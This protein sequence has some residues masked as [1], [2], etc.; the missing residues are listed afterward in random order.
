MKN[1][2][3]NLG[4]KSI[5][6]FISN[7]LK[8]FIIFSST[9]IIANL[10][11]TTDYG[12]YVYVV[13]FLSFFL[14][15]PRF[16]LNNGLISFISRNTISHIRKKELFTFSIFFS[17]LL[18]SISIILMF[19]FKDFLYYTLMNSKAPYHMFLL[20]I[21]SIPTLIF[22]ELLS[23]NHKARGNTK[24]HTIIDNIFQPFLYC[25]TVLFLIFLTDVNNGLV[26]VF[27]FYISTIFTILS[28]LIITIKDDQFSNF[29]F[30]SKYN[31]E[32][33]L[34]SF[35]LMLTSIIGI[36][37]QNV[38][39]YMIGYYISTSQIAIYRIALAFG[40]FSSVT[41]LSV[42]TI[43]SPIISRLYHDGNT[44]KIEII[45]KQTTKGI[46]ILNL[47]VFSIIFVLSKKIM[48]ISGEEY[49]VGATAL[50]LVSLGQIFNSIVGAAGQ[51]NIMTE[52]R[53]SNFYSVLF[54]F[55]TNITLNFVLIGR[56]GI[57]GV[58]FAT[59]FSLMMKN[60]LNFIFLYKKL[61]IQPYNK[62]FILIFLT[63]LISIVLGIVLRNQITNNILAMIIV[64]IFMALVYFTSILFFVLSK[65][66]KHYIYSFISKNIKTRSYF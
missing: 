60:V 17:L 23:S 44:S 14:I 46:T 63:S 59:G 30:F 55:F 24:V 41:L 5:F 57:N 15:I 42:T 8:Q 21:P 32:L 12:N 9:I 20:M 1:K 53:I 45:Y 34:C 19:I 2:N 43:F 38:D 22:I 13:S 16:G 52:N 48:G 26:L 37:L 35:P 10:L 66:E 4:K 27:S 31:R 11:G 39:K 64:S 28:Y 49:V 18:S 3:N 47:F 36:V 6:F 33:L 29:N 65:E 54:A 61:R 58:A 51:I 50:I 25:V 56:Y 40:T 62:S 7:I